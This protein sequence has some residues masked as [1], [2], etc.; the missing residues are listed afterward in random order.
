LREEA[1]RTLRD[2]SFLWEL[3]IRQ[4]TLRNINFK[5]SFEV[6]MRA[7]RGSIL[8]HAT[9]CTRSYAI[10]DGTTGGIVAFPWLGTDPT[11][12]NK[13]CEVL[14]MIGLLGTNLTGGSELLA[15]PGWSSRIMSF[16]QIII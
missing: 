2:I 15:V 16:A 4:A 14:A 1:Q 6:A 13:F 3:L 8:C 11:G 12:S 9:G 7:S 5:W 10:G